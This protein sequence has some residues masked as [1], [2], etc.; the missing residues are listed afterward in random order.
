MKRPWESFISQAQR[1]AQIPIKGDSAMASSLVRGFGN[2]DAKSQGDEE[3]FGLWREVDRV[4]DNLARSFGRDSSRHEIAKG[5]AGHV[6]VPSEPLPMVEDE[7]APMRTPQPSRAPLLGTAPHASASMQ[8]KSEVLTPPAQPTPIRLNRTAPAANTGPLSPVADA[9]EDDDCFEVMVELPGVKEADIDIEFT[10][11]GVTISADRRRATEG[12]DDKKHHIRE[13]SYGTFKR[14]FA[15]PFQANPD[16]I[17]AAYLD[18]VVTVRVP[19][20][21]ETKPRTKK[22]GLKRS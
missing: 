15:L 16:I 10:D 18:G 2:Q 8:A 22:I 3:G 5:F 20:P 12:G 19:R 11:G 6:L 9:F 1:D 4:F 17:D 14:R 13:R 21:P 7:P